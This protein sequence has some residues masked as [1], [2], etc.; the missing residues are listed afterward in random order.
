MGHYEIVQKPTD[1]IRPIGVI[2]K[3]DGGETYS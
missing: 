3:P 2:P 1:I